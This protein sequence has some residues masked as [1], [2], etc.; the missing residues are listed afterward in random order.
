MRAPRLFD[1]AGFETGQ[2]LV[3]EDERA[4]YLRNVL[5]LGQDA[6]VRLFNEVS[7]EWR[8]RIAEVQKRRL[9]LRLEDQLRAPAP[10]P[11]PVLLFAPMKR[12]RLEWLLE[13]AVE[14]GAGALQ[15][16]ITERTVVGLANPDRLARRMVEAAEQCERLSVPPLLEPRP[17]ESALVDRGLVAV[18]DEAGPAPPLLEALFEGG[19]VDLLTGPEGGFSPAERQWLMAMDRVRPVSLGPLVLRAE[20]AALA[21][22]SGWRLVRDARTRR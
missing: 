13:K 7:G 6:E 18:A 15:P 20:T 8:A 3:L 11:G 12:P 10:E 2:A 5:R 16:V 14:L 22:L 21:M 4:H 17:L 9:V 1:E 19:E